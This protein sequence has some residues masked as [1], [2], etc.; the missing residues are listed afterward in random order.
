MACS[1][2]F[3]ACTR[4]RVPVDEAQ[5]VPFVG[6]VGDGRDTFSLSGSGDAGVRCSGD[7]GRRGGLEHAGAVCCAGLAGLI[8][9]VEASCIV[10]RVE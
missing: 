6:G 10:A 9:G 1:R 3:W 2:A 4:K 8:A 5:C 7:V